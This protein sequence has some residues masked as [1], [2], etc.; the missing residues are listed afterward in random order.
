MGDNFPINFLRKLVVCWYLGY[1]I[2][3]NFGV[4]QETVN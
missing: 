1:Q 4:V 2:T 3:P